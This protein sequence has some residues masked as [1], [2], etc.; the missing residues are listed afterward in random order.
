MFPEVQNEDFRGR[1]GEQGGFTFEVLNAGQINT[2]G[3][4][5][6]EYLIFPP[7]SAVCPFNIHD[8]NIHILTPTHPDPCFFMLHDFQVPVS[9]LTFC[10]LLSSCF[11]HN[12]ESRSKES[13]EQGA[14]DATMSVKTTMNHIG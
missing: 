8:H 3:T 7:L 1:E 13:V 2:S 12:I 11:V 5:V 14:Y 9:K 6:R 4:E 10:S